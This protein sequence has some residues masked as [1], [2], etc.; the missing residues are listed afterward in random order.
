MKKLLLIEDDVTV[1]ENTAELLELSNYDVIT[2][3]NG[4]LGIEKAEQNLPDIIVC[5]IMMPEIDGYGVLEALGKNPNT[6]NI[7]FIFLSAKTEHKDIRK[8]MDLGADD[9]LTKP[10]EE[11]ELVSAIESR[12]AKVAILNAN[13]NGNPVA[14]NDEKLK[15]LDDLRTIFQQQDLQFIKKGESVY[16]KDKHANFFYLLKRGVVKVH[17]ID[18]QGKEL[19]TELYKEDDFFGNHADDPQS[20]YEDYATAMEDTQL[21]A[22]S[23]EEFH[24]ILSENPKISM[25]LVEVLSNNLSEL[26]QQ[27]MDMAYGSV[28]KKTA[29][30]IMMFAE[31]IKKHPLKSIRISRA[32]LAGVAGMAPESLIRTLSEF[33]KEGLIEIEGR[34]IKLLNSEALKMVK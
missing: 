3:S 12:L 7:P 26:K 25:Q 32:D 6:L 24:K 2:A 15:T 20:S 22:L 30:T 27:L 21:Y 29:K 14:R 33:K 23:R 1:R 9:Y 34:N 17:R 18:N 8:G 10:F 16:E 4:M 31:R 11:E 5:D 28:R 19:I 13:R